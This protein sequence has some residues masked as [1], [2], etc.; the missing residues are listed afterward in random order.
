MSKCINIVTMK[1]A[2]DKIIRDNGLKR[3][4]FVSLGDLQALCV[5]RP[6]PKQGWSFVGEWEHVRRYYY[7]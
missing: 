2:N 6:A 3:H 7:A 1:A 5:N 4:S